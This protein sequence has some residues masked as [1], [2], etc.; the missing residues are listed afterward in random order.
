MNNFGLIHLFKIP[1]P[2]THHLFFCPSV[3]IQPREACLA[4]VSQARGTAS[5]PFS[6]CILGGDQSPE[7]EPQA[8]LNTHL[9]L[10][11]TL[12]PSTQSW[13]QQLPNWQDLASSAPITRQLE[14][15][16]RG[17]PAIQVP[18]RAIPGPPSHTPL[19]TQGHPGV[20]TASA[21]PGGGS[22]HCWGARQGREEVHPQTSPPCSQGNG[23]G[24]SHRAACTF[25]E[26]F[27]APSNPK[28][29]S[30]LFSAPWKPL[31]SCQPRRGEGAKAG[32]AEAST[33][34]IGNVVVLLHGLGLRQ[35]MRG[36][37]P[38]ENC[39]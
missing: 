8:Q 6:P 19:L 7:G 13:S 10:R 29:D 25:W 1:R 33:E 12:P 16:Q 4:P 26:L 9:P 23:A 28:R 18:P 24:L 11:A 2:V 22:D 15:A 34:P 3:G 36:K 14:G 5:T 30:L 39:I 35:G 32:G 27:L 38:G 17:W 21:T 20:P 31:Q 37:N